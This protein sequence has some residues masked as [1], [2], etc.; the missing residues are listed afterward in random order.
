ME[1]LDVDDTDHEPPRTG[2]GARLLRT[3]LAAVS[4][5]GSTCAGTEPVPSA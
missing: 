2:I 5:G 4:P 1:T 3:A